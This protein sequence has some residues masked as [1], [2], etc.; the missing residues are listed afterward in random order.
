MSN[1]LPAAMSLVG[2]LKIIHELEEYKAVW[3]C[4]QIHRGPYKGPKYDKE[5]EALE[6]AIR[7][8]FE[9]EEEKA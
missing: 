5:L 2:K 9:E 1:L 7:A 4:A 3:H 8:E 6:A